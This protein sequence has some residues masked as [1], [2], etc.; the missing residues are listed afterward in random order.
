LRESIALLVALCLL[1][2][3][4]P[5]AAVSP[6]R[7]REVTP[8]EV[9]KI[10][11]AMPRRPTVRPDRPR[12]LLVFWLCEGFFHKSIPL[13]NKALEIMGEKT[14]AF[15]T[16]ITNDMFIFE[17]EN[18]KQF[19]AVCFNNTTGLKFNPE[20]TSRLCESLMNF[21]KGGKGIV[22]IHA[23]TDNFNDWPEAMEMMGG[24][25]TGPGA[26]TGP[27]RLRLMS[28]TIR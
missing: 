13:C 1:L 15:E 22:G 27:G 2:L 24:K 5:V 6:A 7:L 14:G 10:E 8:E 26:P 12:K 3:T 21:V 17:P 18:L 19:D 23:A 28:P 4:S 9:R 20:R 16:V 11:K 25:F